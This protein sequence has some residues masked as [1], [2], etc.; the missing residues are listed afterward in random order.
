MD[1]IIGIA[2]DILNDCAISPKGGIER[3]AIILNRADIAT[4]SYDDA[5]S[6]QVEEITLASGK[7]GYKLRGFKNSNNAGHSLVVN[8]VSPDSYKQT[9]TLQAWGIDGD[10]VAT[11]DDL[12]D[13]VIITENKNKGV[14]G[15]G[16]FEIY[17]LETGLYK[18]ADDRMVAD[19]QG[20]QTVTLS[21]RDGEDASVSRHIFFDTDYA[22]TK[23]MFEALLV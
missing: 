23:A 1:C 2:D 11:L 4:I 3:D 18:N 10:T 20:I 22:T 21:T 14:N 5:N 8:D 19:N 15:N 17:G 9:V 13:L 7:H 16:A 12:A 6:T